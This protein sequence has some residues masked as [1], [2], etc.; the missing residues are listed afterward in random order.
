MPYTPS[1]A[2]PNP[3][4]LD[5]H[6]AHRALAAFITVR[7]FCAG[8]LAFGLYALLGTYIAAVPDRAHRM[9][10]PL[11]CGH[12]VP[13]RGWTIAAAL[14][15]MLLVGLQWDLTGQLLKHP[16][17]PGIAI[18]DNGLWIV[19]GAYFLLNTIIDRLHDKATRHEE[20]EETPDEDQEAV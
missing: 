19:F 1:R 7:I 14:A 8:W 18:R 12:L 13:R 3:N 2:C 10:D 20:I 4:C 11:T 16:R 5:F 17:L 15:D 6:S 9:V